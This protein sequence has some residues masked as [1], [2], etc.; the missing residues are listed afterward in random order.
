[1]PEKIVSFIPIKLNNQRLPGKNLLP[2]HGKPACAYLFDVI[3]QVR[4]I[5]E[6]YVFCSDE[7][8]REY[9]PAGLTFLKREK[10]LDGFDVKGLDIIGN[11]IETVDADIYVLTHVTSPFMK[12][13]SFETALSKILYEGYD[14]AFSAEAMQGYCWYQGKPINYN[15]QDIVTTQNLEAVYMETGGFFMFRKEVF[16]KYH[17]RIGLNPYLHVIDRF[18]G[19]DID[20]KEDFDYAQAVAAFLASQQ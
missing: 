16:V 4:G 5:D 20:T 18:E 6:K 13:S 7:S 17:R 12:P 11:F 3:S 10:W 8:I 2:L 9:M 1:M 15:P 19:V 14:S